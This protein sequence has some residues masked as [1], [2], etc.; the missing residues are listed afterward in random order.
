MET[1]QPKLRLFHRPRSRSARV[2]WALE[3]AGLQY[4]LSVLTV[5]ET[6]ATPH[7][8]RHPLG[9]VPVLEI[10]G[11]FVFESAALCLQVADLAP[12]AQ[13]IAPVGSVER[14][15]AYQW[16]VFAMTEIEAPTGEV[17][18]HRE[19][20][21]EVAHAAHERAVEA[22]TAVDR[23]LA[24]RDWLLGSSFGAA[25]VVMASVLGFARSLELTEGL[26]HV[27]AYLERAQS[28]PAYQRSRS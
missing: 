6:R 22:I 1:S 4:E 11:T 26:A 21:P 13:L 19:S 15:L 5:E 23:A 18:R 25:D 12:A 17:R 10:D 7:R 28:R 9:R 27:T 3:E 8:E 16:T 24:G 14:A 2:L 20:Q